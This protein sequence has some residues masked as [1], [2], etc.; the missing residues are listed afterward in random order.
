MALA[1]SP[2]YLLKFNGSII[3]YRYYLMSII[4]NM[5][6][7]VTIN[8]DCWFFSTPPVPIVVYCSIEG[9]TYPNWLCLS[10][11]PGLKTSLVS[12]LFKVLQPNKVKTEIYSLIHILLLHFICSCICFLFVCFDCC[13]FGLGLVCF[14]LVLCSWSGTLRP[15]L[16]K[17]YD[18]EGNQVILVF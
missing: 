5:T 13:C 12:K 16:W 10:K 7:T 8:K 11:D 14:F 6:A 3:K 4:V 15:F 18:G 9:M 2:L 1:L 17:D